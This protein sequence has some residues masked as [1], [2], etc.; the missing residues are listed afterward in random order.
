MEIVNGI[1]VYE[2]GETPD[3][4]KGLSSDFNVISPFG[5]KIIEIDGEKVWAAGTEA[6]YRESV[7]KRMGI[8]PEDVDL[9]GRGKDDP[10]TYCHNTGPYS[11][12]GSCNE[13]GNFCKLN[14]NPSNGLNYC[15]CL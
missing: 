5:F 3:L 6:E 15:E 9:G 13:A 8:A 2:N 11:C 7:G 14:Y 12:S 1:H 10:K 4:P